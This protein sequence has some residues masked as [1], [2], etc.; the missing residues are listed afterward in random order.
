MPRHF[1]ETERSQF[2]HHCTI[3][4]HTVDHTMECLYGYLPPWERPKRKTLVGIWTKLNNMNYEQICEYESP[5]S[6]RH[7]PDKKLAEGSD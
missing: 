6:Y 2:V 4:K 7:G 5:H 1:T 3:L